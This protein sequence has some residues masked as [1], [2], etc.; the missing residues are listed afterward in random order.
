VLHQKKKRKKEKTFFSFTKAKVAHTIMH[1]DS[2]KPLSP[3]PKP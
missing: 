1:N 2:Q 3:S